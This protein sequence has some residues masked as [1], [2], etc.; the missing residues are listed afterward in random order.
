MTLKTPESSSNVVHV[1]QGSAADGAAGRVA[2]A[3]VSPAAP[4]PAQ[5]RDEL[6]SQ[7]AALI[8]LAVKEKPSQPDGWGTKAGTIV[9]VIAA[10]GAL[11][12]A[13]QALYVSTQASETQREINETQKEIVLRQ[14]K[15]DLDARLGAENARIGNIYVHQSQKTC[16]QL[17]LDDRDKWNQYC[18]CLFPGQTSCT[19]ES[20]FVE[21]GDDKRISCLTTLN[22][23]RQ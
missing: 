8:A 16:G 23:C 7:V 11:L 14:G 17:P 1:P 10:F 21:I 3:A 12:G 9:S 15:L 18:Q 6:R 5:E 2:N 22:M 20:R 4:Q 19:V 13:I